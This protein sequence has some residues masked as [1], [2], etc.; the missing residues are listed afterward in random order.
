MEGH[1]KHQRQQGQD[2]ESHACLF[3]IDRYSQISIQQSHK[4]SRRLSLMG[5]FGTVCASNIIA[6]L[7]WSGGVG[8]GWKLGK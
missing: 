7:L 3:V 5:H 1:W 6:W 2:I 8:V 4:T